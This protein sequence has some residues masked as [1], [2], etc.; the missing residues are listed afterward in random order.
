[1]AAGRST[2]SPFTPLPGSPR[3]RR[4]IARTSQTLSARPF[5][6]KHPSVNLGDL[7]V[8]RKADGRAV[9]SPLLQRHGELGADVPVPEG[10]G[11]EAAIAAGEKQRGA[12]SA[13]ELNAAIHPGGE[14]RVSYPQNR[15]LPPL[16][17]RVRNLEQAMG[18]EPTT[19]TVAEA[20]VAD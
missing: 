17:C 15:C 16:F 10:G 20:L 18:F 5:E 6:G 13:G 11:E 8:A 2:E 14:L 1:M 19:P 4:S 9:C 3:L 7:L 12:T